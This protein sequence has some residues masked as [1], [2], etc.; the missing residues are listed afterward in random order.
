[1]DRVGYGGL[2]DPPDDLADT[3]ALIHDIGV[4]IDDLA[5]NRRVGS[6]IDESDPRCKSTGN[7]ILDIG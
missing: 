1:M 6:W 3:A 7:N 4:D 5:V 2:V